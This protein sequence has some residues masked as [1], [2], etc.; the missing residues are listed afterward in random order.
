[1]VVWE[2]LRNDRRLSRRNLALLGSQ[3]NLDIAM[4]TGQVLGGVGLETCGGKGASFY[5]KALLGLGKG[6]VLLCDELG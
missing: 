5:V 6:M 1:M 3:T 4:D 2:S